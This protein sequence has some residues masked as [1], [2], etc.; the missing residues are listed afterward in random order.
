MADPHA[1]G[2][3]VQAGVPLVSA[4]KAIVM[5]HGRGGTPQ[6][7]VRLAILL[8]QPDLSVLAIEAAGGSWWPDSFLAPLTVNEPYITSAIAAME[9]AVA[10]LNE[11]GLADEQIGVLG[12]SQGAC[13]AL[14][15]TARAGRPL[16]FAA[17]L[18][19]ALVGTGEAGGEYRADLYGNTEKS[20][21]YSAQLSGTRVYLACHEED[22]HIPLARVQTSARIFKR[23]NAKVT[24]EII[25]GAGHG[26]VPEEVDVV[27]G[28]VSGKG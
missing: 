27:R 5:A 16:A 22:P 2:R 1:K 10:K 15:Y 13:L 3:I 26:I 18:S 25:P 6:D 7:M 11:A 24:I 23:M 12:F 17:A 4:R 9:R 28:L 21:D 8:G 20:F 14:E 19:G